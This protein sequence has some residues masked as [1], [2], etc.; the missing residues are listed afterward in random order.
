[1]LIKSNSWH[2]RLWSAG[3][4][5]HSR[6][7][8]LCKYFWHIAIVKVLIPVIILSAAVAGISALSYVIWNNAAVSGMIVLGII[9][10]LVLGVGVYFA[11]KALF[12]KIQEH[13]ARN[14]AFRRQ[15]AL[16]AI[17]LPPPEPKKPNIVWEFIKAKKAKACPLI[18]VEMIEK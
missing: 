12:R 11:L 15:A 3:R 8:N 18:Q 10:G 14:R 17:T 6:P 7:H 9:N 5:H 2:Y 16:Q 4:E 13:R 1:M